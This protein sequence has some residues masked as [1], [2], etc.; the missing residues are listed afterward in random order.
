[1]CRNFLAI[2]QGNLSWLNRDYMLEIETLNAAEMYIEGTPTAKLYVLFGIHFDQKEAADTLKQLVLDESQPERIR[3][4]TVRALGEI[5]DQET[6]DLL[7]K[8]FLLDKDYYVRELSAYALVKLNNQRA[9]DLFVP[10]YRIGS[11]FQCLVVRRALKNLD[12][13]VI[14]PDLIQLLSDPDPAIRVLAASRLSQFKDTRKVE[15]L[16]KTLSDQHWL[17]RVWSISALSNLSSSSSRIVASLLE[18]LA[19]E[20]KEVRRSAIFALG[21]S[22]DPC[23]VKPL[24]SMLTTE[25]TL[26]NKIIITALE[27]INS[28]E[29][30]NVVENWQKNST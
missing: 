15:P 20:N 9:L 23:A 12:D 7:Y 1:M 13:D 24:A 18:A 26:L 29:A 5:G 6:V 21:E 27:K 22:G 17:V 16:L 4:R 28:P 2:K 19:D 11:D 3:Y 8:L 30:I 25:P 10:I 14:V